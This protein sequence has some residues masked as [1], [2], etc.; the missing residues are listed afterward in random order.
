MFRVHIGG[1]KGLF[2]GDHP[3]PGP[4]DPEYLLPLELGVLYAG[5]SNIRVF[6]SWLS[7]LHLLSTT[8]HSWAQCVYGPPW[9]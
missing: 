4:D 3:P 1:G 5:V 7:Q 2:T 9:D 6:E 8:V